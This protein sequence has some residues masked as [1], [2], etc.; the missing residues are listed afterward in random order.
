MF[1]FCS[2]YFTNFMFSLMFMI[3]NC[4]HYFYIDFQT[5]IYVILCDVYCAFVTNIETLLH[6]LL[7]YLLSLKSVTRYVIT[8]FYSDVF[9]GLWTFYTHGR[10]RILV[11]C[12]LLDRWNT[13]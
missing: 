11:T 3:I 2:V 4:M 10:T 5:F 7:T 12:A 6:S 9:R 8:D 13:Y 1:M